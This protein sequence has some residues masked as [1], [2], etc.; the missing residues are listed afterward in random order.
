MTKMIDL[1]LTWTPLVPGLVELV[2][3]AENLE[4]RDF[5]AS[6]L[7]RMCD[8]AGLAPAES[9][10]LVAGIAANPADA[11][12]LARLRDAARAVDAKA[13]AK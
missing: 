6:E 3:R 5:A 4:T 10:R 9:D 8:A 12:L 13:A 11:D 2:T 7:R 1:Q